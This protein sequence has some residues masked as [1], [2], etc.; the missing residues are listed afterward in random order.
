MTEDEPREPRSNFSWGSCICGSSEPIKEQWC[1]RFNKL[2]QWFNLFSLFP[3][4]KK[5]SSSLRKKFPIYSKNL[6]LW[7]RYCRILQFVSFTMTYSLPKFSLKQRSKKLF[8]GT[9]LWRCTIT[10]SFAFLWSI[11][12]Y[13]YVPVQ[14]GKTSHRLK[15]KIKIFL[16]LDKTPVRKRKFKHSFIKVLHHLVT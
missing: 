16:F 7:F 1:L 2:P 3:R 6:E 10:K 4:I 13:I 5:K 15:K 9:H 8:S 14:V 12:I 11:Y